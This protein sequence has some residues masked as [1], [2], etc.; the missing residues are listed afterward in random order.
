[1]VTLSQIETDLTT[2]L[3]SRD[4]LEVDTLRGLKTRIQNE[5]IAKSRDLEEG[6]LVALLRSEAKRR[7]E[8]VAAFTEGNRPE[9]AQKEQAELAI[10]SRYLPPE[11]SEDVLQSAAAE[12]ITANSFTIAQLGQAIGALKKQFPDADGALVAKV[13][14]EKLT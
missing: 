11:T 13:I 3:K 12:I 1:M 6:E 9:L 5:K 4:T 2:A 8:A 10:L 7:K 14:K